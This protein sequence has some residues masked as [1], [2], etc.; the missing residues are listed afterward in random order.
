MSAIDYRLEILR[1]I[2]KRNGNFAGEIGL[3]LP[4]YVMQ[5]DENC[6]NDFARSEPRRILPTLVLGGFSAGSAACTKKERSIKGKNSVK[7]FQTV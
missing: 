3:P 2:T 5:V 1:I 7:T 6:K 4:T